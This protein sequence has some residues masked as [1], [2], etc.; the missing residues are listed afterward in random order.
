MRFKKI[1][2]TLMAN[3]LIFSWLPT[4]Y[5][6]VK[7]SSSVE[8]G[9][10]TGGEDVD[11]T[12]AFLSSEDEYVIRSVSDPIFEPEIEETVA[13]TIRTRYVVLKK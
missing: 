10:I 1:L 5:A 8:M 3:V 12:E 6:A 9:I 7:D 4:T 2:I 11:E 13:R